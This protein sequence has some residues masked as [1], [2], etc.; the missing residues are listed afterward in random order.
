MNLRT[1]E[2]DEEPWFVAKDVCDA[3][4][5]DTTHVR[6]DL[7]TDERSKLNLGQR[8]LGAVNAVSESDLYALVVQS[9]KPEARA[10]RKWV[11]SVVLPAIRRDGMY[12]QGREPQGYEGSAGPR[13]VSQDLRRLIRHRLTPWAAYDL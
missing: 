5:L 12:V 1:V 10:F 6:R 8:G 7:D 4:G 13:G 2:I 3:L 9:R 11:T